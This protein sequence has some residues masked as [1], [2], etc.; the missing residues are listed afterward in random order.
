T[1]LP[2]IEAAAPRA[3][4]VGVDRAEGMIAEAPIQFVRSV[5][6]A[7]HLAFSSSSFDVVT[8]SFVLFHVEEPILALREGAR[9]LRAGGTIG[10]LTWGPSSGY[11]A[12]DLW[13]EQ[14]DA[15]GADPIDERL[16]RHDLV[17]TPD[18]MRSLLDRAGFVSIRTWTRPFEHRQSAEEFMAHRTGHGASKRRFDS[19]SGTG[20]RTCLD[21]VRAR[22]APLAPGDLTDRAEIVFSTAA[23]PGR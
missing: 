20:R 7:R 15:L 22:L 9:V 13:Y 3:L 23:A 10:A 18:K 21:R 12:L 5:M 16:A 1:S 14:L 4:V 8:M 6:D 11:R 19:L 2:E 17:D